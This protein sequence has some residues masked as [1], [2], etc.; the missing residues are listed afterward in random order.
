MTRRLL[1]ACAIFGSLLFFVASSSAA[2]AT[3]KVGMARAKIT[4]EEPVWLAGYAHRDHPADST[5]HDIWVK[6]LALEDAQGQRAVVVTTDLLG[7][8]PAVY[9]HLAEAIEKQCG[10]DRAR[11]M[12]TTSHTHTSPVLDGALLDIYPLED[13]HGERIKQYTATLEKTIIETVARSLAEMTPA[14][15]WASE[16]KTTLAVNR[17]NNNQSNVPQLRAKGQLRGPSDYDVPVL[18]V[19]APEG[20]LRAVVFGYACHPTALDTYSYSGDYPGFAQIALEKNLPGVQAMFFQGCGA[21]QNPLPR[22]SVELAQRYGAMLADA[23]AQ[24]LDAVMRPVEPRLQTGFEFI[25]LDFGKT[26]SREELTATAKGTDFQAR[27]AKRF[28]AELDAG[29]T[30]AT[31]TRYPV[32]VWRLGGDQLWIALGG[33]VVV[34]YALTFKRMFGPTTWVAG[35]TNEVIA[36]IPSERVLKEGSYEAGAFHVYGLPAE[37]WAP[38]LEGRITEAVK[39]L[40]EKTK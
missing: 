40:V 13:Q 24:T 34:D 27:G 2:A 38:G 15:L 39:R 16:G 18:A 20:E 32:Q 8:P 22:R 7:L 29:R 4:P 30:F 35:Y 25:T 9:D 21:D 10:L 11:V 33:E 5:L 23:V 6:A 26:L 19:R 1:F 3:W 12:L 36:Y 14:T 28:L 17:R 31:T 37:G